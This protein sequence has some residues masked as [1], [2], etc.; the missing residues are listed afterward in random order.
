MSQ[1]AEIQPGMTLDRYIITQFLGRGGMGTVWKAR[2]KALDRTVA[3]KVLHAKYYQDEFMRLR[4]RREP[5]ALARI[6]HPGVPQVISLEQRPDLVYF[7]MEYLEGKRLGDLITEE[8]RLPADRAVAVFRHVA[9]ALEAVHAAGVIHRDIK[10]G[11]VILAPGGRA[12]LTDFGLAKTDTWS[13]RGADPLDPHAA[14]REFDAQETPHQA[15]AGTAAYMAPERWLRQEYDHRSDIYSFGVL[16][17]HVLTGALPFGE[18]PT[19]DLI[20]GHIREKP[21]RMSSL[22]APVPEALEDIAARCLRKDPERRFQGAADIVRALDLYEDALAGRREQ[23]ARRLSDF[24]VHNGPPV[25]AL[26]KWFLPAGFLGLAV[27]VL[28]ALFVLPL[29]A[30]NLV[31]SRKAHD[32]SRAAVMHQQAADRVD[33]AAVGKSVTIRGQVREILDGDLRGWRIQDSATGNDVFIL[34]DD[35]VR[36]IAPG[37][38]AEARGVLQKDP[39]GL[40]YVVLSHREDIVKK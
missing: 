6:A 1:F 18:E 7:V 4:F 31:A 10:P 36:G 22:G 2:D 25:P 28:F 16:M 11:N 3:V 26:G 32:K 24:P 37:H 12:V 14:L 35:P 21:P 9:Q 27:V 23:A 29:A 39:N 5:L 30:L 33:Q 17:F 8:Y 40:Y 20:Q 34:C 19:N 38:T 13:A 15:L